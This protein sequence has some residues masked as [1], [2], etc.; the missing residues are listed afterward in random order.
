[1]PETSPLLKPFINIFLI[2]ALCH[3]FWWHHNVTAPLLLGIY[4]IA[5]L[6]FTKAHSASWWT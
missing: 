5:S 2:F 4:N 6:F 3:V 1:M